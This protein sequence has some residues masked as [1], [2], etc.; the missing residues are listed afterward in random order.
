MNAFLYLIRYNICYVV[1]KKLTIV[2]LLLF[3]ST[4]CCK[5]ESDAGRQLDIARSLAEHGHTASSLIKLNNLIDGMLNKRISHSDSLVL[6]KTYRLNAQNY[7]NLG[8]LNQ[9][10]V[11]F[12]RAIFIAKKIH[13]RSQLGAL[14]NNVF[15]LYYARQDYN[16][17]VDLLKTSLEISLANHD[18]MS[19]RNDYN[20]MG[21]VYY[22]RA[23]FPKALEYMNK[24]LAYTHPADKLGQSLIYTNRGEVFT[25]QNNYLRAEYELNIAMGLLSQVKF[26]SRMLQ[27]ILNMA[28]V[29]AHLGKKKESFDLQRRIY[30]ILPDV[31]ITVKHNSYM[32]LAET[33]FIL[34]DSLAGLRNILK[35]ESL[36]DSL[37]RAN[38]E[39]QLQQLLVAYDADRLKKKNENLQQS[40]EIFK[41]MVNSRTMV[42]YSTIVFL[43]V[44][45]VMIIVLLRRIKVDREKNRVI[46]EQ[47]EM[48][49]RYEQQEHLRQQ[50]ELSLEIDHKNRQLTSY[51]IDLTAINEFH[52]E[53]I[54][55]L[56]DLRDEMIKNPV[57]ADAK[58]KE[59]MLSL[60]H[61]NDK[62]LKNDFHVFFD[63][64]HPEF[65]ENLSHRFPSLTK[66][67][68]RLCAY[69]HIGLS[70]KEIAT[71]TYR[72]I[73]SVDSSRNRLRKKLGI[74]SDI[75]IQDF[76]NTINT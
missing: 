18:S 10:L 35:Y 62:P 54:N 45:A 5:A 31:P 70:T 40:V 15:G 17:A 42:I 39:S 14:Y 19:I 50:Q 71:L 9:A 46:N 12:R 41:L 29:K 23:E 1:M 74:P 58:L 25:K 13:D 34:G 56:R 76:L 8:N 30:R 24:A 48:L 36:S 4:A 51:T 16:Q 73:R 52:H 47:K 60:Q 27:T 64:V 32:Q 53:I 61:Y 44:F 33:D 68:L 21:L 67:D 20:N 28:L 37:L 3:F 65:L 26:D 2:T 11:Y 22:E 49:V 38:N 55:S 66:S 7:Q 72:E 63:E 69:L 6:L 43:I 75:K 57:S 59:I